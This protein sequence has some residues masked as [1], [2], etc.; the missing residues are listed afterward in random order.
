LRRY[1]KERELLKTRSILY[2]LFVQETQ[3]NVN[4]IAA[5]KA[6]AYTRPLFSST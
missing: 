5:S 3:T 2:Q 4:K 6:G 1:T